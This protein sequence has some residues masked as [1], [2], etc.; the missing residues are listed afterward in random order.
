MYGARQ[1]TCPRRS[2]S[3]SAL[4]GNWSFAWEVYW[5]ETWPPLTQVWSSQWFSCKSVWGRQ[6]SGRHRD[7]FKL[8]WRSDVVC[9]LWLLGGSSRPVLLPS[10]GNVTGV[11]FVEL[12]HCGPCGSF[13]AKSTRRSAIRTL[14]CRCVVAPVLF[15]RNLTRPRHIWCNL[16]S[17][18]YVQFLFCS[19][20][21]AALDQLVHPPLKWSPIFKIAPRRQREAPEKVKRCPRVPQIRCQAPK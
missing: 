8:L 6:T 9:Q 14:F 7:A 1:H 20:V 19:V 4:D 10:F 2:T 17:F 15:L 13:A 18:F 11:S 16:F 3:C 5:K 12:L 21:A